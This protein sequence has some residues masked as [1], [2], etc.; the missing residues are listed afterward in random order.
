MADSSYTEIAS[1]TEIIDVS[2]SGGT[3]PLNI[4]LGNKNVSTDSVIGNRQK[5]K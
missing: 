2:S 4:Y 5:K 3:I 1:G